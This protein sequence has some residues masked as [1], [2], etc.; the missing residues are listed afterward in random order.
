MRYIWKLLQ[1]GFTVGVILAAACAGFFGFF[2]LLYRIVMCFRPKAVRL[3]EQRLLSHRFYKVSGRARVAYLT[4]CLEEALRFYGQELA[5][6]EW[7]LQRMWAITDGS[8]NDWEQIDAWLDSVG[9][10]LP[11]E[12]LPNNTVEVPTAEVAKARALYTQ[13][14]TAMIV[15]NA[16]MDNAHTIAA[17]WSPDMDANDPDAL[18]HIDEAEDTMRCFGVPLPAKETIQPLLEQKDIALGNSFDGRRLS[19]LSKQK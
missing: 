13:A 12:V 16:I 3:E 15:I 2:Y 7:I 18:R 10:L 19:Y 1:D 5:A 17:M 9:D 4:L 11:Y 8:E 6:W 14:G